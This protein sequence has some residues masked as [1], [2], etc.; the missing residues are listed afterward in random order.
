VQA[1]LPEELLRLGGPFDLIFADPPYAFEAHEAL[2]TAI[3][4]TRLLAE[5][6][7]LCLEHGRTVDLPD[8][9]AGLSRR[10]VRPYGGTVLSLYGWESAGP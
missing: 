3:A 6:G 9:V 2:L 7:V 5:E 8:A 1:R 10:R 4:S